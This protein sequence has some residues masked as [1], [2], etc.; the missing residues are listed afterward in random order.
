VE[1]LFN[2]RYID[3]EFELKAEV[4]ILFFYL[5]IFSVS[6]Y[7]PGGQ[8]VGLCFCLLSVV[9][10]FSQE[11]GKIPGKGDLLIN[12]ILYEA[13]PADAEYLELYNSG[14]KDIAL[15]EIYIGKR[16]RTGSLI[17][18][19]PIVKS[20]EVL[21]PG[22]LVWICSNPAAIAMAYSYHHMENCVVLPAKLAYADDGGVVVV[23]NRNREVIDEVTYGKFLHHP[24]VTQTKGIALEKGWS[25]TGMP[26]KGKWTS[27][28]G[29]AGNGFGSPGMPNRAGK[30]L[31]ERN[32]GEFMKCVPEVFTPDGDGLEDE[33]EIKITVPDREFVLQLS[34][35]DARGRCVRK[36]ADRVPV[37]SGIGFSWNGTSGDGCLLPAG[38][39]VIYGCI[40]YSDGGRREVRKVC[41]LSR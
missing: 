20:E 10:V 28:G 41:V 16:D 9:V 14:N 12:E 36:I 15:C 22:A 4:M 26:G 7:I 24:M 27:A 32:D 38:I 6:G 5:F 40:V 3:R 29:D 19:K 18:V 39:Y 33:L 25:N 23:L 17:A 30:I 34:V 2:L 8:K 37:Y 21:K 35:Y 1:I 31:S 13:V 11:A